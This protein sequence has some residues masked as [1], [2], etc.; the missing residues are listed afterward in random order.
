MFRNSNE[1]AFRF[2]LIESC[3]NLLCDKSTCSI[4]ADHCKSPRGNF[5]MALKERFSCISCFAVIKQCWW[6][7][8][9]P[10]KLMSRYFTKDKWGILED[11]QN[12]LRLLFGSLNIITFVKCRSTDNRTLLPDIR[13]YK[14]VILFPQ[15]KEIFVQVIAAIKQ[16]HLSGHGGM[17]LNNSSSPSMQFGVPSD[18]SLYCKHKAEF[19]HR[20]K[21]GQLLLEQWISSSPNGQS[22]FPSQV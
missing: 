20:N 6:I 17:S 22:F 9:M 11:V 15:E 14:K 8:I 13:V 10:F 18:T 12:V 7:W 21:P 5:S 19:L 4:R 2:L 1:E 16:W 3:F